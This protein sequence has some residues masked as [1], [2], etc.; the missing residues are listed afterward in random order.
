MSVLQAGK[1]HEVLLKYGSS[2]GSNGK[3][4]EEHGITINKLSETIHMRLVGLQ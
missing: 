1:L 4:S 2:V 3:I